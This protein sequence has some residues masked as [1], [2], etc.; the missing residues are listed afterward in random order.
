MRA[1]QVQFRLLTTLIKPGKDRLQFELWPAGG[2]DPYQVRVSSVR[3]RR[4][5]VYVVC[6]CALSLTR[7]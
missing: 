5:V 7:A 4:V 6:V 1:S 3:A 2:G